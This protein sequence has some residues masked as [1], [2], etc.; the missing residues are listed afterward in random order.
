VVKPGLYPEINKIADALNQYPQTLA[1]VEGH[2]D[3][4]GTEAYNTDLSIRRA[5]AVK[6]LLVQRGVSST[7]IEAIGFGESMPV[8]GNDT[9]AGRARNRRVEIKIAPSQY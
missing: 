7:R 3:S 5:G 6:N 1:R 4:T 2:T 8:A 9:E